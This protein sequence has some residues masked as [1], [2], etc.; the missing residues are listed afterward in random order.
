MACKLSAVQNALIA[1]SV[2]ACAAHS[3]DASAGTVGLRVLPGV[4]STVL[5][6]PIAK[7]LN[8]NRVVSK[9][10][11]LYI[12]ARVCK[13]AKVIYRPH[14]WLVTVAFIH[15]VAISLPSL[16][17]FKRIETTFCVLAASARSLYFSAVQ[18][19]TEALVYCISIQSSP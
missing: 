1:R 19:G 13:R 7:E 6:K 2:V 10:G 3:A 12:Q 15:H 9:N 16:G 4:Y 17:L 11:L 8:A 18:S 5:H 14:S